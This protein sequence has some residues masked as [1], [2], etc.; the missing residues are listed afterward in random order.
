MLRRKGIFLTTIVAGALLVPGAVAL[1]QVRPSTTPHPAASGTPA[2]AFHHP[3]VLVDPAELDLV[4]GKVTTGTQPWSSAFGRL[5]SAASLTHVPHPRADVDCGSGSVPNLGCTD[6][7]GDALAAYGD[8][9]MWYLTK[10]A[11]Y[12]AASIK[13]MDAWSATIRTHTNS[14]APLQT[15]WAGVGWSRAAELIKWTTAW[16]NADRFATMLRTVYLPVLAQGSSANGNWELI[17]TDA[18]MGIAVFL[19]DHASFDRAVALWRGRV[20]AYIYLKSDGALP[21]S[22]PAHPRKGASLIKYWF[23]Q[24]TFVDG[25]AQETCRDFGHTAMG[26]NAAFHTAET[27]RIQGI[28]LWD[29]QKTRLAAGLEFHATFE[30]GAPVPSWLC[31]GHI[32]RGTGGYWELGYNTLHTRLGL[33]LPNTAKLLANRRPV[34]SDGHSSAFETLT[35][36]DNP[37]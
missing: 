36:F 15:G 18:L 21:L 17:M 2:P 24:K 22:P 3:G 27:A 25:L 8:A 26:F 31:G 29:E 13:V 33:N 14:N 30:L 23:G 12:A 9:L 4:R 1:A 5:H 37:A 20:P 19:D 7:R 32:S 16:P 6:E 11:R 10:D 35:F 34:S 28:D